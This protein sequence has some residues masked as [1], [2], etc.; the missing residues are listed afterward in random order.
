MLAMDIPV[1][2]CAVFDSVLLPNFTLFI[3]GTLFH[4]EENYS[5]GNGNKF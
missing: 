3:L 5:T 2:L 4:I 1:R